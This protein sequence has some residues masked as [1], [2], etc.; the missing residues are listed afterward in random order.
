MKILL[1]VLLFISLD[2]QA[3]QLKEL[4]K[5]WLDDIV[6]YCDGYPSK[7]NC[8]DGDSNIFNGLLCLSGESIGCD[9]VRDAQGRD[10]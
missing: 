2:S 8:D 5:Y 4:R 3:S 9:A 6:E 1:V 10:G 7:E